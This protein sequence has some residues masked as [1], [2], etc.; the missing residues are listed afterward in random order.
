MPGFTEMTGMEGQTSAGLAPDGYVKIEGETW[1]AEA[2]E[3][4]IETGKPVIVTGQK[5]MKLIVREMTSEESLAAG[6]TKKT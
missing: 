2:Q 4:A 1:Q 5:G 6:L 3:G